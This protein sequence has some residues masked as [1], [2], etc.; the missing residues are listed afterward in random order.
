MQREHNTCL[1]LPGTAEGCHLGSRHLAGAGSQGSEKAIS[2]CRGNS[3]SQGQL[4][5]DLRSDPLRTQQDSYN[6]DDG[7]NECCEDVE[8]LAR[9]TASGNSNGAAT[10]GKAGRSPKSQTRNSSGPATLLLGVS[11]REM[12]RNV[13]GKT[14]MNVH[15]S[16]GHDSQEA[17]L[18][19]SVK[20]MNE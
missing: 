15:G 14:G 7:D 4:E 6:K 20:P 2:I 18:T 17:E 10:V 3:Y 19:R 1:G 12:N 9:H 16:I 5:P 8:K 11:Q 13:H